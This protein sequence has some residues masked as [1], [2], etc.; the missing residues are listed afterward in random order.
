MRLRSL[1][2]GLAVVAT[3]LAAQ[4]PTTHELRLVPASIHWGYF[5]ATKA[6]AIRIRSGDRVLV[7]TFVARGLARP[8]LG[9]MR[10]EEFLPAERAVEAAV[11]E[12]GPG[13]HPL[14]GPIYVEGAEP[15]DALEVRFE[16]I[17]LLSS[18]GVS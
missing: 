10:D 11:T 17:E 8:R 1:L 9:G 13:P 14:N 4:Q 12:R 5:D 15:G 18:W 3:P 2:F 16:R 7:E 6:P